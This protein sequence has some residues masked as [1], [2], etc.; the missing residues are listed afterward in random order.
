MSQSS[1]NSLQLWQLDG[2][3]MTMKESVSLE[4]RLKSI[5]C[6][7]LE[8]N[9]KRLLVGTEG[10]N[11]YQLSLHSFTFED[12]IIYQ[13]V[14][15]RNVPDNYK[16]NPGAVEALVEHPGLSSVLVVGYTRG[17]VLIWDRNTA[18]SL[19]T[20]VSQQQLESLHWRGDS[21]VTCHNDGSYVS[22]DPDTGEQREPPSTP[23]GPYP[24]KA[25][26]KIY[27]AEVAGTE[28]EAEPVSWNIFSGGMPRASYG[29]KFT[30]SV[31]RNTGEEEQHSVM[32][33]SSKVLDWVVV[34]E[35]GRPDSI[36]ILSEEELVC[37]DLTAPGWPSMAAPYMQSIHSSAITAISQVNN[38]KQDLLE[39]LQSLSSGS[40]AG[41]WPVTGGTYSASGGEE[42][43]IIT[44]HEDGSVKFWLSKDNILSY[45]TTF[46]TKLYFRGEDD[47]E[48]FER[49]PEDDEEEWPPFKKVG[50]FDP[51]SDDPRLAVKKVM[52]SG[53]D[54]S[55]VVGGTA[56]QVVVANMKEQSEAATVVCRAETVTEKEGFVWKGHKALDIK[57]GN[58]KAARGF[59]PELVLQISP[60][61]SITSLC[62]SE[63]WGETTITL[64]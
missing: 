43:V 45:L 14:L 1:D 56:G 5:S 33:L 11:I 22:W 37:V 44:G 48:E 64:Y 24:C 35:E 2:S 50:Q 53:L 9:K 4:G 59:Q 6:L 17:L 26:T 55:L 30:V 38:V 8:K 28:L 58:I 63:K 60:P 19:A 31:M 25:I 39:Q 62:L 34:E 54:G 49:D 42:T 10:G 40:G 32:D 47:D 29:D 51:Y 36:L 57:S 23:Y 46:E 16:L 3:M 61:A 13:D 20:M 15:M 12:E 21:L 41:R 18:A 7:C 52:F 27:S